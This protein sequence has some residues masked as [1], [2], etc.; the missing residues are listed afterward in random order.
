MIY[1]ILSYSHD[2]TL[3]SVTLANTRLVRASPTDIRAPQ[4]GLIRPLI[5]CSPIA[6]HEPT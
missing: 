4:A 3:M 6:V 1:C 2:V 5:G